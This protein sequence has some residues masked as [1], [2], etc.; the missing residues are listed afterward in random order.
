VRQD[1]HNICAITPLELP[2][3]RYDPTYTDDRRNCDTQAKIARDPHLPRPKT[4]S[5]SPRMAIAKHPEATLSPTETA[6]ATSPADRGSSVVAGLFRTH[7]RRVQNFLAFRLRDPVEAQDV[8]QDVFL[9]LWRKEAQ[10]SLRDEATNYMYAATQSAAIDA[11]RHSAYVNR[12]RNDDVDVDA[13]V[14]AQPTAEDLLHW[15]RGM[16]RF[17][18]S[19]KSLPQVTRKVFVLFHFKGLGY[20]E[21]A[22]ELGCSRRTVERHIAAGLA[23]CR[24][25]MKDYL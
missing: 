16:A 3:R 14:R 22:S 24:E 6:Q 8:A 25:Q 10:G 5:M 4:V 11:D 7:G 1:E 18:D 23:Y 2:I 19:V 15:R 17:V 12:D 20:D 21:I 9:K 13:V